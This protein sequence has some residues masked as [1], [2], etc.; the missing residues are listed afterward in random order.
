MEMSPET[1]HALLWLLFE[2]G[3]ILAWMTS[4][5]WWP[6]LKALLCRPAL[7]RPVLFV[8]TSAALGYGVTGAAIAIVLVPVSVAGTFLAPQMLEAAVPGGEMLATLQDTMTA[9]LVPLAASLPLS[10][11]WTSRRL[12]QRW[13]R[14]CKGY[15][16]S[17]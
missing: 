1:F 9:A 12:A 4:P 6:V 10:A 3:L 11:W 16:G 14:L 17:G 15:D 8:A 7:P 2:E 13:P 5:A